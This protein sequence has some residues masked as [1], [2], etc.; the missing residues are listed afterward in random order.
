MR[1]GIDLVE[2]AR[3]RRA[4]ERFGERF[5]RRVFTPGELRH[6]L[7]RRDEAARLAA[8]FAAKEA[9][10]KAVGGGV[11][12][13]EVEVASD[14]GG[15]PRLVLHGRASAWSGAR[16]RLSLSHERSVAAAVVILEEP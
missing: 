3:L 6:C 11:S 10:V 7:G 2:V 12:W 15:R 8:R 1:V 9:F 14:P 5:L 16:P 4:V 13:R